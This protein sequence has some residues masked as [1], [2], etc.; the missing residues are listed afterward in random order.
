MNW[1]W[2]LKHKV[3]RVAD[4][5]L[6]FITVSHHTFPGFLTE[7]RFQH[8]IFCFLIWYLVWC[9]YKAGKAIWSYVTKLRIKEESA[10][11][12]SMA[13]EE[14]CK[15]GSLPWEERDNINIFYNPLDSFSE[16]TLG[17]ELMNGSFLEKA[18]T[19]HN[20]HLCNMF[21]LKI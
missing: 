12:V 19:E 5:A 1:A 3:M 4:F 13:L 8:G 14:V 20:R 7:A 11:E 6:F 21:R 18:T 2:F 16:V 17:Y 9:L 15:I 10:S